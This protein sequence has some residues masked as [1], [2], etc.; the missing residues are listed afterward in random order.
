MLPLSMQLGSEETS[1]TTRN[2]SPRPFGKPE[3]AATHT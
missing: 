3:S 1:I 2:R